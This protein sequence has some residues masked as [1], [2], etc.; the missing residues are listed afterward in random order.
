MLRKTTGRGRARL[1]GR[2]AT[3]PDLENANWTLPGLRTSQIA[4]EESGERRATIAMQF[5]RV[6]SAMLPG[7]SEMAAGA[8]WFVF[9]TL[10]ARSENNESVDSLAALGARLQ[11]GMHRPQLGYH[12]GGCSS[13]LIQPITLSIFIGSG[14]SQLKH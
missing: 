9:R 12:L 8:F 14:L 6:G 2:D 7:D 10:L 11:M 13:L 5:G 3:K 4:V 1:R